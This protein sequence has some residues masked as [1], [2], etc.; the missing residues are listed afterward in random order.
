MKKMIYWMVALLSV[1]MVGCSSD[2]E[3]VVSQETVYGEWTVKEVN[4]N[5]IWMEAEK[6]KQ[7]FYI[8]LTDDGFWMGQ[9]GV[10]HVYQI[11]GDVVECYDE[12]QQTVDILIRFTEMEGKMAQAIISWLASEKSMEVR[13]I[14]DANVYYC[15]AP[16]TYLHGTWE[17]I[18]KEDGGTITF[19]YGYAE[20]KSGDFSLQGSYGRYPVRGIRTIIYAMNGDYWEKRSPY[21]FVE[22]LDKDDRLDSISVWGPPGDSRY[23]DMQFLCTKK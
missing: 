4:V 22:P 3:M 5:G 7:S 18:N 1:V 14:R 16:S 11:N 21:F 9:D 6:A 12:K 17:I 20:I 15:K 13:M 8:T 23:G 19:D 10:P 2:E